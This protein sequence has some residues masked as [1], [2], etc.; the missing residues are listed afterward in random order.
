MSVNLEPSHGSDVIKQS[1]DGKTIDFWFTNYSGLDSFTVS[2]NCASTY[3]KFSKLS[4]NTYEG[5]A[6]KSPL[7][8]RRTSPTALLFA[9]YTF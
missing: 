3:M 5:D 9:S 1:S 8:E 2:N 4:I 6:R 7:V